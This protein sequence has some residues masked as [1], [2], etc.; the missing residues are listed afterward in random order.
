MNNKKEFKNLKEIIEPNKDKFKNTTKIINL[1]KYSCNISFNN[2]LI[3]KI[4]IDHYYLD[5]E[6]KYQNSNF[7]NRERD[8]VLE[9]IS[10]NNWRILSAN[11]VQFSL[12][13][14]YIMLKG[15]DNYSEFAS[16][17]HYQNEQQ[18]IELILAL[19]DWSI[20]YPDFKE[21]VIK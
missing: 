20:N 9:Y 18:I 1:R 17:D 12:N 13:Y 14:K 4:K 15:W 11:V 6:V 10:C 2:N 8:A 19:E 7:L 16:F 3:V 5:F 21:G